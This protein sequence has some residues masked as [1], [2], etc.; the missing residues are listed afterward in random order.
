MVKAHRRFQNIYILKKT[1]KVQI[2]GV[3][4]LDVPPT[5]IG[6]RGKI[7]WDM[8]K[9]VQTGEAS[10]DLLLQPTVIKQIRKTALTLGSGLLAS[11]SSVCLSFLKA[12]PKHSSLVKKTNKKKRTIGIKNVFIS[13]L[14]SNCGEITGFPED[15]AR[16]ERFF[17]LFLF[18]QNAS[19]LRRTLSEKSL[20]AGEQYQRPRD[21][22]VTQ[23]PKWKLQIRSG[24]LN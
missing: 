11:R 2:K 13:F 7:K 19:V 12:S 6:T 18:K 20:S 17:F 4:C 8:C 21:S 3:R 14:I 22:G 5:L 16:A 15:A 23:I 10:Y 24:G 9:S 1:T